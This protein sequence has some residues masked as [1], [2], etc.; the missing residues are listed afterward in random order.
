MELTRRQNRNLTS[1]SLKEPFRSS[2]L[3]PNQNPG[4]PELKNNIRTFTPI[5]EAEKPQRMQSP[6]HPPWAI[7]EAKPTTGWKACPSGFTG[8]C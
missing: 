4:L 2:I 7:T 8:C 6:G 5:A 3:P 1:Y